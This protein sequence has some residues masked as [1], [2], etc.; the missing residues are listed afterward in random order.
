MLTLLVLG[1][2]HISGLDVCAAYLYG[3]LEEEL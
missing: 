3:I 2:W 1:K